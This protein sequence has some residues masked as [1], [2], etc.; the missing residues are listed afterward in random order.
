MQDG[1]PETHRQKIIPD[2]LIVYPIPL[3]HDRFTDELFPPNVD[4][5]IAW[6]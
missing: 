1:Y 5:M 4:N 3:K 6:A 2:L